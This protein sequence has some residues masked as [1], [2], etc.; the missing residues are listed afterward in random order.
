MGWLVMEKNRRQPT[1]LIIDDI[2]MNIRIIQEILSNAGYRVLAFTDPLMGLNAAIDQKPD[3]ILLDILMPTMS[4]YELCR[5]LKQ[6]AS[7]M[8]IPVLFISALTASKDILLAFENG[9]ADYVAKPFQPEEILARVRTHVNNRRMQMELTEYNLRLE[10]MVREQVHEIEEAQRAISLALGKLVE[11]RD[12][13][14]GKHVER[15]QL[16]CR[17]LA[18]VLSVSEKYKTVITGDY[19]NNIFYASILHDIGKIRIPD[20]ILLKP[21]K[22]TNEEFEIIKCHVD[23]GGK[24]LDEIIEIHPTNRILQMGAEI[25][26]YHHEKWDGSGYNRGLKKEE[27]PLSARIMAIAD[28]Y[29]ALRSERPYKSAMSHEDA[30]EL[31]H[32]GRGSH[33]DPEVVDAFLTIAEEFEFED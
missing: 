31:M 11:Y 29:D 27:I 9:G 8:Q 14:T 1:V 21:D 22:L 3:L 20:K 25:A 33:F 2:A 7:T 24:A 4:G 5:E 15:V 17:R 12:Y 18:K 32:E 30:I 26:R 6:N 13:E 23:I 16:I 19:V 28:V 10:E